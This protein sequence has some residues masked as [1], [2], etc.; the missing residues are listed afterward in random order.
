MKRTKTAPPPAPE[1]WNPDQW[2]DPEPDPPE[3]TDP[4][5]TQAAP[6][7]DSEHLPDA[8]L[9]EV[10]DFVPPH[11]G[12]VR[13]ATPPA[14]QPTAVRD[15]DRGAKRGPSRALRRGAILLG[16]V[17]AAAAVIGVGLVLILPGTDQPA[18]RDPVQAL[19][20][21]P[22][23]PTNGAAAGDTDC[24]STV[25]GNVTTGRDPGDQSSGAG[26]VKAFDY[27]YYVRRDAV[28][29]RALGTPRRPDGQRATDAALHRQTHTRNPPLPV[30]H[31]R[32]QRPLHRRTHR[33][34][35]GRRCPD[36][37]PQAC[38]NHDRRRKELDR[39]HRGDHLT[40]NHLDC[41]LSSPPTQPKGP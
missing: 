1:P 39:L 33:D 19:T 9:D 15:D 24:P 14:T 32:R 3:A 38:A 35:T 41:H 36:R 22:Q 31:Q 2:P 11:F 26:V 21:T 4:A 17:V 28:A 18:P 34:R 6:A 7:V 23:Q 13:A 40:T 20:S 16:A 30:D 37:L 27:A 29:A 10:D 25:R 8:H 5:P 12:T